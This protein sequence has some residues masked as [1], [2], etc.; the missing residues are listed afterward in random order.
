MCRELRRRDRCDSL[1]GCLKDYPSAVHF[2]PKQRTVWNGQT[3]RKANQWNFL[4]PSKIKGFGPLHTII[5]RLERSCFQ[6]NHALRTLSFCLIPS[7]TKGQ[8]YAAGD[9]QSIIMDA[10]SWQHFLG[11]GT[12]PTIHY[13]QI[14]PTRCHFFRRLG[15]SWKL[16]M[17]RSR[18]TFS[19]NGEGEGLLL[20]LTL[21]PQ[22]MHKTGILVWP[23]NYSIY[24]ALVTLVYL[25][26]PLHFVMLIYSREH[27]SQFNQ[28]SLQ[29]IH[30]LC[31]EVPSRGPS[32]WAVVGPLRWQVEAWKRLKKKRTWRIPCHPSTELKKTTPQWM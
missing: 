32:H 18:D 6:V 16:W 31:D 9:P 4:F 7:L 8:L 13:S 17:S 27:L 14:P 20:K 26:R 25:P 28:H 29:S 2:F 5:H 10:G 12:V 30:G 21:G 24:L 23:T 3:G 22:W 15:T 11:F 1:L 19:E